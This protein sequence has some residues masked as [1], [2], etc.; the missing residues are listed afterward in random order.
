MI[1]ESFGANL[2]S[3]TNQNESDFLFARFTALPVRKTGNYWVGLHN[4]NHTQGGFRW[5][6]GT[7][8]TVTNFTNWRAGEPSGD[9]GQEDC[10]EMAWDGKWND[11]QVMV[12]LLLL[13]SFRG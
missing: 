11:N 12:T 2:V 13:L 4:K 3:I 5:S 7:N 8:I 1:C 10:V 6:D 9:G